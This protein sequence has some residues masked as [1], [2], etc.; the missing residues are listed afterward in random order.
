MIIATVNSDGIAANA[1]IP[2]T[3]IVVAATSATVALKI[4]GNPKVG[5]TVDVR[6]RYDLSNK[7]M[8]LTI[9]KSKR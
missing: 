4:I 7:P 8:A 5:D 6:G 2:A 1:P 3:R 9:T